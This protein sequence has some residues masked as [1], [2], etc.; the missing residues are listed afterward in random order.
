MYFEIEIRS[1]LL[2]SPSYLLVGNEEEA[3]GSLKKMLLFS[4]LRKV[5]NADTGQL[6]LVFFS[7]SESEMT[8]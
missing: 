4:A 7:F 6:C 5:K 2:S 8:K 3:L 1:L